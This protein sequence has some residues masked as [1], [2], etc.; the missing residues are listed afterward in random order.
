MDPVV[1]ILW[2]GVAVFAATSIVAVLFLAGIIKG[3]YQKLLVGTL[4]TQIVIACTAAI[5][6]QLKKSTESDNRLPVA[7]L[8]VVEQSPFQVVY[9][10]TTAIY[11]RSPDVSRAR[12]VVDLTIDLRQDFTSA[13]SIKLSPGVPESVLIANRKYRLAFSQMGQLDAD[14]KEAQAPTGDFVF[15]SIERE[16]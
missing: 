7:K 2:I 4:I 12:R 16:K 14:P 10:G 3:P 13:Q 11:L 1:A 15:L 6:S 5:A 8:M 9:D